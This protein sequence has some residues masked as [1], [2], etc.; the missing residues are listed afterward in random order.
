[1]V[2][3]PDAKE[4]PAIKGDI[5][6]EDVSHSYV[7]DVEVLH[8]ID[9]HIRAGETVALV[10]E[11]GAGKTTITALIA[12]LY[13]VSSGRIT[14]DGYDVKEVTQVSLARRIVVRSSTRL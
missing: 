2:D 3:A 10:G 7:A 13:E 1:M 5:R 8:G 9:L 11:T 12:R 14:L 4:L 6:F